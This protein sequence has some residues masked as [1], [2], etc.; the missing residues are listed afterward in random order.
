M[1]PRVVTVL[2]LLASALPVTTPV[3]A[4]AIPS[5]PSDNLKSVLLFGWRMADSG[6]AV[7]AELRKAIDEYRQRQAG[8]RTRLSPK[9]RDWLD[10]VVFEKRSGFERTIWSLFDA[11][12]IGGI[13]A[14]F[15]RT[16][17][18]FYEWEGMAESP[19]AEARGAESYLREHPDTPIASFLHLF[20][21]HRH[22]CTAQFM[23]APSEHD[24][25]MAGFR[26]ELAFAARAAHPL[27]RFQAMDLAM[28]PRCFDR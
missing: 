4:Q 3:P 23:Q 21:A 2:M 5:I 14:D 12:G 20:V 26:R 1:N 15:A 19:R 9:G 10:R 16:C 22:L 11:P 17:P 18:L 7:P 13:A 24:D 28:N 6:V 25:E 27:I 8:F